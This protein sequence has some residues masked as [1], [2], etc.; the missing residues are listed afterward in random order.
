MLLMLGEHNQLGD[1]GQVWDT[2]AATGS[3]VLLDMSAPE[4]LS[5]IDRIARCLETFYQS[6]VKAKA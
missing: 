6:R 5:L 3:P 1:L 2:P 4:D